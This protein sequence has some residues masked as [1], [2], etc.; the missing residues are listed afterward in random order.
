[1]SDAPAT[2]PP[3]DSW[4]FALTLVLLFWLPLPW[5][6]KPPAAS[7][8]LGL[9]AAALLAARLALSLRGLPLPQL[10]RAAQA[11]SRLWLLDR[12]SVV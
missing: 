4:I 10:P 8:L 12:K 1:M 9:A 6:S 2:R 5:G 3:S 11:V 7:A